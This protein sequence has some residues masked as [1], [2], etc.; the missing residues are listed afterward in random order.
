MTK[1][2]LYEISRD[3]NINS[4]EVVNEARELGLDVK[5]HASTV[6]EEEMELIKESIWEQNKADRPAEKKPV[7][8]KETPAGE[9]KEDVEEEVEESEEPS[10]AA[11]KK[12]SINENMSISELAETASLDIDEVIKAFKSENIIVTANQRVNTSHV[13]RV[14]KKLGYIVELEDIFETPQKVKRKNFKKRAPVVTVLGHVDH[15]KTHMLDT[16]RNAN[17]IASE[18]GGITQHIGAYKVKLPSK[19]DEITFIDTPGHEAF[20][21]MRARGANITDIVI[22][23]VS[24]EDGVMP[25]TVEAI[26]HAK[27][28]GV[29]IIVAVNKMDLPGFDGVRT[30]TQLT[31]HGVIT[32]DLGGDVVAVDISA[33]D[34]TNIQELLEMIVLQ[35]EMLELKAPVDGPGEGV[36]IESELDKRIGATATLL[37]T[38]GTLNRG[39]CF[40][41]G[42]VPGKVKMM[43]DDKGQKLSRALPSDP[44]KILGFE[45]LPQAGDKFSVIADRKEARSIAED[46]KE[47]AKREVQK[48]DEKFTLEDLKRQLSGEEKNELNVILKTDFTGSMEAIKD[49]FGKLDSE[50]VQLNILH[51]AVGGV[52]KKDIMLAEASDAIII[53]FNVSAPSSVKKEAERAGVEIR[54]YRIIY[55]I[56][57]DIKK[58]LEGM[59]EPEK[60]EMVLGRAS[61]KRIFKITGAGTV[62]GCSVSNGVI[63]RKEPVRLIRDSRIV[64]D[65]KIGAL[66]RFKDDVSEVASGYECGIKIANFNDIK[67]GDII[68]CYRIEEKK[69]KL[70]DTV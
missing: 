64:Y 14:M 34:G 33:K 65:G 69:R 29:P 32:E 44:V 49:A 54:T 11:T 38:E 43:S 51:S 70:E 20:T 16:I 24:G 10:E 45:E 12:I 58:A 2:R 50:E 47:K 21:A 41:C 66:K 56:I 53:G 28:A 36:I 46:R 26:N 18:S 35:A 23:L 68:E 62:A 57:E 19:E 52:N 39:D 6:S 13:K 1:V 5:S 9:A 8:D 4:E 61:V 25:Q 48:K 27:A 17:V 40:V 22:L 60:E 37:V 3:L 55:E 7:P 59:L 67:E 63:K 42:L 31:Q 30:R 15:G